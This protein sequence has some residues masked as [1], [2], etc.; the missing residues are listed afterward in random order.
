MPA[1]WLCKLIK[2]DAWDDL[3]EPPLDDFKPLWEHL[4]TRPVE[5]VGE[6][7]PPLAMKALTA[8]R[9]VPVDDSIGKFAKAELAGIAGLTAIDLRNHRTPYPNHALPLPSTTISNAGD[10]TP[11]PAAARGVTALVSDPPC[12]ERQDLGVSR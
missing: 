5:D 2:G 6:E 7:N 9:P 4:K 11:P 10:P 8:P 3:W 1:C 12:G